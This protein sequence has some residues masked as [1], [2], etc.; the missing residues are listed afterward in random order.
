MSDDDLERRLRGA[1][2]RPRQSDA[3]DADAFLSKVHHGAKVRRVKRG[4]S[5]AAAS[6]LAVAGGGFALNAAGVLDGSNAPVAANR[7]PQLILTTSR[8][9]SFL[10]RRPRRG[11]GLPPTSPKASRPA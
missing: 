10:H 3:A 4:V 11:D 1:L 8:H 7:T 6:V 5:V 9:P 2:T